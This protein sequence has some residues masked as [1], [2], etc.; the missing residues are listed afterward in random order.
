MEK[1]IDANRGNDTASHVEK[2]SEYNEARKA[3]TITDRFAMLQS[4]SSLPAIGQSFAQEGFFEGLLTAGKSI[5]GPILSN[6]ALDFLFKFIPDG[7]SKVAFQLLAQ[8]LGFSF[9][10]QGINNIFDF[11]LGRAAQSLDGHNTQATFPRGGLTTQQYA[12]VGV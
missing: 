8:Q 2:H 5:A 4:L 10:Q 3:K 7:A 9:I 6:Q 12:P 11:L 1:T